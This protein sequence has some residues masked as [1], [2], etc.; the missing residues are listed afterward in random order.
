M[1]MPAGC[2]DQFE[3]F[4]P[5]S[6]QW[7]LVCPSCWI[8]RGTSDDEGTWESVWGGIITVLSSEGLG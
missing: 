5:H 2:R 3:I 8:E 1:K 6:G 4:D 7:P